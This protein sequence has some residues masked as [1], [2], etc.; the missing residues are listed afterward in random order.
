MNAGGQHEVECLGSQ[1]ASPRKID[2]NIGM[3]TDET[4]E[5]RRL[6][7]EN[8]NLQENEYGKTVANIP[9]RGGFAGD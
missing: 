5:D 6:T 1:I 4:R 2:T 7:V 8:N 3:L 9:G